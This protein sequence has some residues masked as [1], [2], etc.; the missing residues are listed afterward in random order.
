MKKLWYL[1]VFLM[2]FWTHPSSSIHAESTLQYL[3]DQAPEH[4][5]VRIPRGVYHESIVLSK[6]VTLQG[7]GQVTIQSCRKEPVISIKGQRVSVKNVTVIQC[8]QEK[9]AAAIQVSGNHHRIEHVH[10]RTKGIGLKL[11]H[12]YHTVITQS[13]I[14]GEKQHN[15]IDLWK[16]EQNVI[17]K[18]R[19]EKVR[20]GIYMEQSDYTTAVQN[21]I[22]Q[23]NYGIHIMY[24]DH[25]T[26]Q[27]NISK[28]NVAG[29]MVMETKGGKIEN[30][31]FIFNNRNVH[32]QGILLFDATET[33]VVRN[34]ISYNRVGI[35]AENASNNLIL[36]NEVRGN[37]IGI[38][39]KE[40]NGNIVSNNTFISNVNEAQA[41]SSSDNE[42]K[43]NYWDA[44][45]KLDADGSGYSDIPY[46]T[47]PFFLSLTKDIPEYQLFF[48]SPGMVVLQKL[49]K[50]PDNEAMTDDSPL[51]TAPIQDESKSSSGV[52]IVF[53]LLLFLGSITLWRI[54]RKKEDA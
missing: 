3:I 30:N 25:I 1:I 12:A 8:S 52:I 29:A 50:S 46:K 26:I 19:I 23:S 21:L 42:V 20:D 5:I 15:G 33:K 24:S 44:S 35:F 18:V 34:N 39:F 14:K 36:S 51:M 7:N 28:N 43:R 37:F 49:W 16:S 32:A 17:E 48:H 40:A 27:K 10:I 47:N 22:Q 54:G 6:P 31:E 38:Q 9:N 53:S 2:L 11:E 4:S 13:S 45:L 41:L